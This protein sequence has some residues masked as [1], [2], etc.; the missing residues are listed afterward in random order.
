MNVGSEWRLGVRRLSFLYGCLER[1]YDSACQVSERM[2][3]AEK[4]KEAVLQQYP[5]NHKQN[6]PVSAGSG[7]FDAGKVGEILDECRRGIDS[8]Q[9]EENVF[10]RALDLLALY[11]EQ[12]RM[13]IKLMMPIDLARRR[14]RMVLAFLAIVLLVVSWNPV[15]DAVLHRG[16]KVVYYKGRY[17]EK[18]LC[19]KVES[20]FSKDY[21]SGFVPVAAPSTNFSAKWSG[22]LKAPRDAE[23]FFF[24]KSS[25]HFR[26]FIDDILVLD[27]WRDVPWSKSGVHGRI[28]LKEGPHSIYAEHIGGDNGAAIVVQWTGGGIPRSTTLGRP[29]LFR[30]K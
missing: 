6:S 27:G 24:S 21:M 13:R 20:E 1:A 17:F 11:L 15:L 18:V 23:Y 12:E 30:R 25:G 8:G 29:Y 5:T 22:Y 28:I 10:R 26:M 2:S 19:K 3:C 7:V 14:R 16:L 9:W 4:I